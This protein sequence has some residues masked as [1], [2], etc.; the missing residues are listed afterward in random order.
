[1]ASIIS[2]TAY[3]ITKT[4]KN[5]KATIQRIWQKQN[6]FV[7]EDVAV[8]LVKLILKKVKTNVQRKAVL[9]MASHY[10]KKLIAIHAIRGQK[11]VNTA[12]VLLRLL[13]DNHKLCNASL[14][15]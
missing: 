7:K 1:M 15:K 11:K 10:L 4:F 5:R 6:I 14:D 13:A 3:F 9:I 8:Q 2:G 12:S